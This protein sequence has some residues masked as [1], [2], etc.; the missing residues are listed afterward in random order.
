M[1]QYFDPQL[2]NGPFDDP[3]LYVDLIFQRRALLFDLGDISALS[4]RKLMR[5]EHVFVT[6]RHMDHFIGFDR[7]LRCLLGREKT[8]GLWGG[9]GLIQ[10]VESKLDAYTWNLIEGYDGNLILRVGE[11][12]QNA[13]I[14]IAAFSGARRFLREDVAR[15][16]CADGAL[17]A[18]PGFIVRAAFLD[19]GIPALAFALEERA[20]IN[21]WRQRVEASG[22]VVGPWLRAF[23]DAVVRGE[24]DGVP[25]PVAW[26]ENAVSRPATLPLGQLKSQI[27][28]VT[29]GRKIAYV[30]DAAYTPRNI[31]VILALARGADVLFI[32]A[33]FLDA[34]ADRAAAR[35][36]L[37][38]RQAGTLAR[39][40]G[41][42]QLRTFHYSPRYRDRESSL[43]EEARAA[44]S[45]VEAAAPR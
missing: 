9:P 38:A 17:V 42:S 22:L 13:E 19:H 1:V 31:E 11:L 26:A 20:H 33:P 27:M 36:H 32:E 7:L 24:S 40:A 34:E 6:H 16:K 4:P 15:Y 28:K 45:N 14:R 18:D 3:G 35:C 44:F 41:V 2:I 43:A 39:W 25:I 5:L 12:S 21:I 29:R 8:L 23:K 10:A 30:V 37:T